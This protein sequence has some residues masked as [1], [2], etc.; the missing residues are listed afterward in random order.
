MKVIIFGTGRKYIQNKSRFQHMQIIAFLDNDEKKQG[1]FID[2][3]IVDAPYNIHKYKFDYVITVGKY[4]MEMRLQLLSLG[5]D[6]TKILDKD[7]KGIYSMIKKCIHY[8]V[9]T[10]HSNLKKKKIALVT[11]S[12]AM[13]GAQIAYVLMAKVLKRNSFDIRIYADSQGAILYDF[14]KAEI[15]VTVLDGFD[16]SER[17]VRYYFSDYDCIIANTIAL[18]NL[19]SKMSMLKLPIMWWL[20]EEE[21]GYKAHMGDKDII[22]RSNMH[23]YGVG[24]KAIQTFK[25]YAKD[26]DIFD[27]H[28]GIQRHQLTG[29]AKVKNKVVFAM[30]GAVAYHKGQDILREAVKKFWNI[31]KEQAE[32]WIIGSISDELRKQYENEGQIQIFGDIDHEEVLELMEEIDVVICASRY[33]TMPIVLAEGMMLKKVCITTEVTGT[34]DYIV[35]YKNGLVCKSDDVQSLS[36]QIEWVLSNKKQ[37]KSIGEEAYKIYEKEF[38]EEVFEEKVVKIIKSLL[39]DGGNNGREDSYTV[40]S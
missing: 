34:F 28:Y 29:I 20:H 21:A 15:S 17:E 1:S 22:I 9:I 18:H 26:G 24:S 25:K 12:M 6:E 40:L 11:H 5:V 14:L 35:P 37:L 39:S 10:D 27:L 31:W 36:E 3:I 30:I 7:H 19:V 2:G 23:V 32:F 4:Y 38:S 13:G 16:L 33:D 8:D